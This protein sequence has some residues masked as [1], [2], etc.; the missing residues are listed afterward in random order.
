M[1]GAVTARKIL[2]EMTRREVS[3]MHPIVASN[4][5]LQGVIDKPMVNVQGD[6]SITPRLTPEQAKWATFSV[7]F[8]KNPYQ[9]RRCGK[10]FGSVGALEAHGG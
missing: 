4:Q 5:R 6:E 8:G 1:T 10:F 3:L 7:N 9:C 2:Q